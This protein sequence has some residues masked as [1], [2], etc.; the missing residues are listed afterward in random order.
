MKGPVRHG[1]EGDDADERV[2]DG[3]ELAL[4]GGGVRSP[5]PTVVI[6]VVRKKVVSRK[7]QPSISS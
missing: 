2:A 5:Y 1:E 7:G 6:V 4:G 3:E